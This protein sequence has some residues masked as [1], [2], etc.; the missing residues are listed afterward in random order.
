MVAVNSGTA[1][2]HTALFSVGIRYGDRVVTT[3][4][5]YP[6]TA[7]AILMMGAL[8]VF[9]DVDKDNL[10]DA[11]KV[12]SALKS[13]LGLSV[14]AVLPVHLFGRKC[15]MDAFIGIRDRYGVKIIEDASQ[16]FGVKYGGRMLG[17][18]GDAGTYSFYASKNLP[19]YQGGAVATPHREVYQHARYVRRHGL[20]EDGV[21]VTMGYNYEMP[22]N[23]AF[24]AWQYLKLHKPAVEAE[25]GRYS[26][27]DGY[28][29]HLVY[30]HP[31]YQDNPGLW[32]NTGCPNAEKAAKTVRDNC[33]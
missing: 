4:F 8:P 21:M 23:C 25:I 10:L 30:Q 32:V 26:E 14:K 24:H 3:P 7:N 11:D 18:I 2:L 29:K 19:A 20:N 15:D 28:Y 16:A 9:V 6:P 27:R 17:T 31:W 12:E 1:A 22:Y 13:S 33:E 5:T